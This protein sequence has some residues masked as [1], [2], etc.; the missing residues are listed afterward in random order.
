MRLEA[1]SSAHQLHQLRETLAQL[2]VELVS[3]KQGQGR[4]RRGE[5]RC[6]GQETP[7]PASSRHRGHQDTP[8]PSSRQRSHQE[9]PSPSSS[10]HRAQQESKEGSPS[11][12]RHR[13]RSKATHS[14]T[15][16][17][18]LHCTAQSGVNIILTAWFSCQG[19]GKEF[20]VVGAGGDRQGCSLLQISCSLETDLDEVVVPVSV[21][22]TARHSPEVVKWKYFCSIMIIFSAGA[23]GSRDHLPQ[24]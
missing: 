9:T 19:A 20:S 12:R 21:R 7:S 2:Q 14:H 22:G 11:P 4:E 13:T 8:S 10:R 3:M 17:C 18:P 6:R 15:K 16:V 24:L 1:L 23:A 5:A